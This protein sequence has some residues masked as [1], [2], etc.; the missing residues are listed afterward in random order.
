[1]PRSAIYVF[2]GKIY[3]ITYKKSTRSNAI[4]YEAQLKLIDETDHSLIFSG[5]PI[6]G[7]QEFPIKRILTIEYVGDD[8]GVY[9]NHDIRKPRPLGVSHKR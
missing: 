7:T 2:P 5:R 1:M 8:S 6:C 3:R 9:I 4:T